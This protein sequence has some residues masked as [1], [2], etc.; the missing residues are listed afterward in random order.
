MFDYANFDNAVNRY[1]GGI[2]GLLTQECGCRI[3]H[4]G[5]GGR[6]SLWCP[7]HGDTR[8]NNAGT[9]M[10]CD[11]SKGAWYCFKCENEGTHIAH[12]G[13]AVDAIMEYRHL[14]RKEAFRYLCEKIGFQTNEEYE[15]RDTDIRSMFVTICHELF[16]ANLD[17]APY[18]DALKYLHGRGFTM[19]S[20]K[21]HRMGFCSGFDAI[22][23]LRKKG[24]N[25]TRLEK[26]GI[27]SR[28]KKTGKLYPRFMNRVTLM[29]GNNAYG[30]AIDPNNTMRH[31]RTTDHNSIFNEMVL[32]RERDVVFIVEAAFDAIA[33]EQYIDE[34]GANWCAIGTLGTKGVKNDELAKQ[35]KDVMPSEI[36]LVPDS[37]NWYNDKNGRHAAGQKAGLKKARFFEA[38]GFKVRIVVLPDGTDPNDLCKLGVTAAQFEGLVK[39]ALTPAKYAIYCE[40]HYHNYGDHSGNIGF[41]NAVCKDLIKYKVHVTQEIVDYLVLLTRENA[42]EVYRYIY[43]SLKKSDALDYIRSEVCRG[44]T[45]EDIFQE[46]RQ[47]LTVQIV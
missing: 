44:R 21:K 1:Y 14:D 31:M 7:N 20:I 3:V 26:A 12:K 11:D 47:A 24:L 6:C 8:K 19:K 46:M 9:Y 10:H 13:Y 43:P 5:N 33:I 16:M 42:N 23:K 45:L 27:L 4:G 30:R 34:L 25:D 15:Y 41:L 22:Q 37:D 40:A 29:E 2:S 28:S 35:L 17:K 32:G 39:K 36:I 38:L 18:S